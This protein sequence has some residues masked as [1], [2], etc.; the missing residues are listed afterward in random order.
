MKC[1]IIPIRI[2][3]SIDKIGL[4][5]FDVFSPSAQSDRAMTYSCDY[6]DCEKWGC[7][8]FEDHTATEK[9]VYKVFGNH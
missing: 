9:A 5:R 8:N 3:D 2:I 1:F 6:D 7:L 4:T